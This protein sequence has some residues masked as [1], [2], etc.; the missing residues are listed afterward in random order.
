M[1]ES[2]EHQPPSW[3]RVITGAPPAEA[4]RVRGQA[5]RDRAGLFAEWA[6]RLCF[7]EYF[8]RNW[9]AL[10]DCLNDLVA[11]APLT[12]VVEDAAQ[13]LADEP[14]EQLGT[15]LTILYDIA[16]S[17]PGRLEIILSCEPGEERSVRAR[18]TAAAPGK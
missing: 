14:P 17:Q 9:D 8:G 4:T 10:S 12:L 1:P 7:P 18:L 5:C 13:L 16:G 6:A 3:L 2:P 11:E 15:L